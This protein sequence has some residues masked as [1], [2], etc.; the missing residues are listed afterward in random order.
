M[1]IVLFTDFGLEG[2]YQGQ[3]KAALWREAPGIPVI[4]LFADAPQQ[5]PKEASYLLAAYA[6][7]F[8]SDSVFVCVVDPGVGSERKAVA[9]TLDGRW[10]VGPDN[11]LFEPL[12]RRSAEI[13]S[14]FIESPAGRVSASFHGRDIFAPV[15]GRLAVG[16]SAACGLTPGMASRFPDWPDDLP[17]VVYIDHYGNLI[18]GLRAATMAE[19]ATLWLGDRILPRARTFADVPKG[20]PFWYENAN[21]LVEVAVNC[22]R[23]DEMFL[24]GVDTPVHVLAGE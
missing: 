1:L 5:R 17:A 23:A 13:Q 19:G 15:A 11:G 3:V 22:G 14:F 9:L 4:D 12:L 6:Q 7:E 20:S 8:P 2:P 18:T 24:A 10:F 21:G 16:R